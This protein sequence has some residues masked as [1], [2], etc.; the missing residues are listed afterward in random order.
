MSKNVYQ[1]LACARKSIKE[2]ETKKEGYN[3]YS[4]YGYFTPEQISSIT[5]NAASEFGLLHTYSLTHNELGY[6]AT[7]KVIN[8]DNP[9][10]VINFELSTEIPELKATNV[11]QQM[12]GAV[13]Y[14]NRYL[15]MAAYDIAENS[16]DFDDKDNSD[17]D[18]KDIVTR[19]VTGA[20]VTNKWNGKIYN[21]K[22]IFIDNVKV[23][24]SGEQLD[25]LKKHDKYKA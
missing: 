6:S 13:T 1:R 10:E 25:K 5:S 22:F 23:Q 12:G 21:N 8:I 3:S 17:E 24:P 15:L 19:E 2:K 4:K 7:L 14:S 16:L 20:E 11:T 18:K 9:E